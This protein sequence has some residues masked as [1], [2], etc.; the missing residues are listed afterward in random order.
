VRRTR[1]FLPE[2]PRAAWIVLGG[3]SLSA[4]GSGL[5]LPFF[6][7]YLH[8]VRG[9][10]IA[11]AA[12]AV[13]TI[14]AAGLAGNPVGGSLADR[15]GA[16]NALAAGLLVA[17]SG[18]VGVALVREP[19]HAFAAAGLLGFGAAVVWPAQD[20]LLAG[21]VPEEQRSG[22]F[23]LRHATLNGGLA[24]GAL[25]AAALVD[26]GSPR[27][28]ELIY[29]LNTLAFLTFVPILLFLVPDVRAPRGE[30]E[31]GGGYRAVLADRV[32]VR[33]WVLTAVLVAAGYAQYDAA[34]PALVTGEGGL[35]AGALSLVFVANTVTVVVSQLVVLRLMAGRRRSRGIS[36]V[37]ALFAL[38]W[39][40]TVIAATLGG[41]LAALLLFAL[42]MTL[43]GLGETLV[44]PTIPPL[45]NDLAPETL[46]GRYNGAST[47]AWTTGFLTG[48]LLAT[49]FLAA[50][51]GSALFA[52]LAGACVLAGLGALR[53]ERRLPAA[54]NLVGAAS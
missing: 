2:L 35:G 8:D 5:T 37:G 24:L 54:A 17:A 41:S 47:L 4:V 23:A 1:R 28:F 10:G 43:L 21:L 53:L 29:L 42:A 6:L 18:V 49:P 33:L 15:V 27:S 3:D 45:V 14:A 39:A 12:L 34:F 26:L 11:T 30:D 7:V 19:W 46:R 38:A 16:R 44:S 48:P 40:V 9:I 31:A 22:A 52:G 50:G 36:A 25:S 51:L 32:F 20:A 13:A